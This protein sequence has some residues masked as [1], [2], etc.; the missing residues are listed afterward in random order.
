MRQTM[1]KHYTLWPDTRPTQRDTMRIAIIGTGISG[2]A[3]AHALR[4]RHEVVLFERDQRPG[5]HTHTVEVAGPAHPVAVDMGF[6]VYNEPTYP[7][8][9]ALLDELGVETQPTEMS[10]GHRCDRCDVEFGSVGV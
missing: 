4:D 8:F 1:Y 3:A 6:I 7:R 9:S 2:L 5:G 10:F